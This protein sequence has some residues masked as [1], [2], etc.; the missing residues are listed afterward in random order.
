MPRR[1]QS[2][3]PR[4]ATPGAAAPAARYLLKG[5]VAGSAGACPPGLHLVATPIGNLRDMT[6][7][8]IEVLA[9]ADLIACEDTRVTRKLVDHYGIATPLT[10]YHDHNADVAAAKAA[11][12]PHGRGRRGARLRR[13]HAVDFRPRY[14]STFVSEPDHVDDFWATTKGPGVD[15]IV[16]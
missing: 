7:R 2:C 5:Q 8:A 15:E 16:G 14:C 6:L 11:R 4:T 9:A 1:N 10:P 13:G 12:P 3:C